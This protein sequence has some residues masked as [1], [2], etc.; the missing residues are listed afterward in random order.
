MKKLFNKI[1]VLVL[2]FAIILGTG[3][4]NNLSTAFASGQDTYSIDNKAKG[5]TFSKQS[6]FE[7]EKG[8]D[9]S[10]RTQTEN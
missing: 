10:S 3:A 5:T 6:Y 7:T 9:A 2:S 4:F 1:I 8:L